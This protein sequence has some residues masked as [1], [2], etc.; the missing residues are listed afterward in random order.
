VEDLR[1]AFGRIPEGSDEEMIIQAWDTWIE[2]SDPEHLR[3]Y[4]QTTP[5]WDAYV[6]GRKEI[7]AA[8]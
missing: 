2:N 1:E 7:A 3:Q 6:A 4:F 8:G 5:E